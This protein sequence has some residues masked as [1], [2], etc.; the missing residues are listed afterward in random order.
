MA[1]LFREPLSMG[2]DPDSYLYGVEL[3]LKMA[4][5]ASESLPDKEKRQAFLATLCQALEII[6]LEVDLSS[7]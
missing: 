4:L 3:G 7:D 1:A 5:K 6:K 2:V